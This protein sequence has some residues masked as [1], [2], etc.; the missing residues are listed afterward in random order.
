[1]LDKIRGIIADCLKI[2]LAEISE[3]LAF[4]DAETWDSLRHMELIG[5][6]EQ[7]FSIEFT[8]DE[9]ISLQRVVDI[10]HVLEKK[11]TEG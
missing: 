4:K 1:M 8:F 2:P 6:L 9:I 7:G 11:G 3:D 10:R 5:A